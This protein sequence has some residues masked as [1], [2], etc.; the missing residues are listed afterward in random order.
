L[1]KGDSLLMKRINQMA[2]LRFVQRNEPASRGDIAQACGLSNSTVSTLVSELM[3]MGIVKNVG[4]GPSI[5]GRRPVVLGINEQAGHV[6]A[7][8]VGSTTITCGRVDLHAKIH[9]KL[10]I[11]TPKDPAESLSATVELVARLHQQALATESP[12]VLG[13]GVATAGYVRPST[14]IVVS[15]S[16]LGW[17]DV[18]LGHHISAATGLPTQVDN[19]A[20]A[21][22]LGELYYGLGAGVD[23]FIYVAIGNGIGAG[24][25][26][27]GELY[28]GARNGVGEVGHIAVAQDGPRC[29]CGR[30][31][32]LESLASGSAIEQMAQT[33]LLQWEPGERTAAEPAKITAKDVFQRAAEG[34]PAAGVIVDQALGHL[35]V[36]IANVVNLLNPNEVIL[37]GG[38]T[39]SGEY[40]ME[41]FLSKIQPRLLPEQNGHVQFRLSESNEDS[42]LRGAATLVIQQLFGAVHTVPSGSD[43]PLTRSARAKPTVRDLLIP[44][45]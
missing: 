27:D 25:V 32:C 21:A 24:L 1:L 23:N 5:G 41:H 33:A 43:G 35:A 26:L 36:G 3:E 38:L 34:D 2:I 13:V 45:R 39:R 42:G 14:G 37:G 12:V 16:N 8:D 10:V 44:Q 19:N 11:K 15:A 29:N 9:D 7:V 28:R 4:E 40:F 31:G 20:N 30:I 22:A 18:D 6:I 17:R